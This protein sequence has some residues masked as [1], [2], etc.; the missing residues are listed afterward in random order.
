MQA[1]TLMQQRDSPLRALLLAEQRAWVAAHGSERLKN[2]LAV[3]P[4]VRVD[5]IKRPGTFYQ[6]YQDVTC[7]TG[8]RLGR[9]EA[10]A[11]AVTVRDPRRLLQREWLAWQPA[12]GTSAEAQH[13]GAIVELRVPGRACRDTCILLE[14]AGDRGL[15]PV[16]IH[17]LGEIAWLDSNLKGH[18]RAFLGAHSGPERD[19]RARFVVDDSTGRE[20]IECVR[21]DFDADRVAELKR[22]NLVAAP[23]RIAAAYERRVL[24]ER[25]K[26][27]VPL[28]VK[29]IPA[30]GMVSGRLEQLAEAARGTANAV[31]VS[32]DAVY[33]V[34]LRGPQAAQAQTMLGGAVEL[35]REG[36]GVRMA[37]TLRSR[38]LVSVRERPEKG[39]ER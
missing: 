31:V 39:L 4:A 5:D 34:G 1:A 10:R 24:T 19:G 13:H 36:A 17:D 21:F 32:R 26:A 6:A 7:E 22:L 14:R 23:E 3:V 37:P 27:E 18:A 30:H 25:L 11:L 33:V 8:R 16:S 35:L 20:R 2:V 12:L 15:K 38:S 28:P 9:Y 29:T